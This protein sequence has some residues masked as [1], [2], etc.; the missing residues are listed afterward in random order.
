MLLMVQDGTA[1][2]LLTIHG[3]PDADDHWPLKISKMH[4]HAGR[5]R[6]AT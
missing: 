6:N 5:K 4:A 3:M 2:E 1:Y